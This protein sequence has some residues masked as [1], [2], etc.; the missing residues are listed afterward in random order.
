VAAIQS[1]LNAEQGSSQFYDTTQHPQTATMLPNGKSKCLY[2]L[3]EITKN[4]V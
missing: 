1:S 4:S 2:C 3:K